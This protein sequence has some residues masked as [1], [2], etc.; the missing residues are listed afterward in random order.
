MSFGYMPVLAPAPYQ[1]LTRDP[2]QP[3]INPAHQTRF[4]KYCIGVLGFSVGRR[5]HGFAHSRRLSRDGQWML[6]HMPHSFAY[7]SP[8]AEK[9]ACGVCRLV[10][11]PTVRDSTNVN[12]T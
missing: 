11:P 6:V 2:K 5:Q 8:V 12:P 7:E 4:W 1:V 10:H 3:I 9:N